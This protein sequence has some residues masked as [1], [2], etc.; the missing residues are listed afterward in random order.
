MTQTQ[1]FSIKIKIKFFCR[2]RNKLKTIMISE[3]NLK[4]FSEV[5]QKPKTS[6]QTNQVNFKAPNFLAI[7]TMKK[8]NI[9]KI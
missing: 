9:M 8:K 3:V 7:N 6:N 5:I 1:I 4:S 2:A